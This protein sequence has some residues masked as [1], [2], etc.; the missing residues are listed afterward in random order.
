[1][2][3]VTSASTT[4]ASRRSSLSIP[5]SSSALLARL[6]RGAGSL[7]NPSPGNARSPGYSRPLREPMR[8]APDIQTEDSDG[9]K[10][11]EVVPESAGWPWPGRTPRLDACNVAGFSGPTGS[12]VAPLRT[13]S[14]S[15]PAP[16][17]RA[18]I[19]TWGRGSGPSRDQHTPPSDIP[20]SPATPRAAA[21][22]RTGSCEWFFRIRPGRALLR[23]RGGGKGR[24]RGSSARSQ[25]GLGREGRQGGTEQ[26][27]VVGTPSAPQ[28]QKQEW[29]DT[30]MQPSQLPQAMVLSLVGVLCLVGVLSGVG[31]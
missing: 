26:L 12:M 21:A 7:H 13:R 1:M 11:A 30:W 24:G 16:P 23:V 29:G 8:S 10:G 17:R 18:G 4:N 3:P 31:D 19:S 15:R 22:G 2:S 14:Q 6:P 25:G 27:P 5:S 9:G 20:K 28:P